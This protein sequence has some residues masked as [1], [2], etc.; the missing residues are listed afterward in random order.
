MPVSASE[1]AAEQLG[2]RRRAPLEFGAKRA[3]RRAGHPRH[4]SCGGSLGGDPSRCAGNVEATAPVGGLPP[5]FG[6]SRIGRAATGAA[7]TVRRAAR[8][9]AGPRAAAPLGARSPGVV[10]P[11]FAR[12]VHVPRP[13]F[14]RRC[15]AHDALLAHRGRRLCFDAQPRGANRMC[16]AMWEDQIQLAVQGYPTFV[17]HR[18]DDSRGGLTSSSRGQ[19]AGSARRL[20][21]AR[22]RGSSGRGRA[23]DRGGARAGGA[24]ALADALVTAL[25]RQRPLGRVWRRA[26]LSA[27]C[28]GASAPRAASADFAS[29]APRGWAARRRLGRGDLTTRRCSR[30]RRAAAAARGGDAEVVARRTRGAG[31]DRSSAT[32]SRTPSSPRL[33]A[34]RAPSPISSPRARVRTS[35]NACSPTS[36][37]TAKIEKTLASVSF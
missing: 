31:G 11:D 23:R 8:P 19:P 30:C 27:A 25:T 17:A 36:A 14:A 9:G 32:R 26:L 28:H 12:R 1:R 35:K 5:S 29:R 10:Y 4:G 33:G 37:R 16:R 22:S 2:R 13:L 18:D 15:L 24:R 7:S 21:A 20:P 34:A 3:R 6:G